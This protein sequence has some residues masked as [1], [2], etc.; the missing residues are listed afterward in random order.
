M[1]SLKPPQEEGTPSL[2]KKEQEVQTPSTTPF[3]E[4]KGEL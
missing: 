2:A 3:E 4:G 1:E